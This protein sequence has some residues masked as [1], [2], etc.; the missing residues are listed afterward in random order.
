MKLKLE[1]R[2]SGQISVTILSAVGPIEAGQVAVLKA[3]AGKLFSQTPRKPLLI[4]LTALE[5]PTERLS[6]DLLALKTWALMQDDTLFVVSPDPALGDAPNLDAGL[7]LLASAPAREAG[8][9]ARWTAK[10][11]WFKACPP[12]SAPWDFRR[13][14]ARPCP[15]GQANVRTWRAAPV[16]VALSCADAPALAAACCDGLPRAADEAFW[17]VAA[18]R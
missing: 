9:L 14:R 17:H 11:A 4:D 1:S 8:L 7:A 3:G 12:Q 13:V 5:G 15:P 18:D 16:I 6:A 2:D 10:E